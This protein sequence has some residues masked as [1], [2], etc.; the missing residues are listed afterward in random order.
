LPASLIDLDRYP[1]LDL[2]GARGR[3]LIAECRAQLRAEGAAN[4]PGFVRA[5]ALGPLVPEAEALLPRALVKQSRRNVY[6]RPVDPAW[7]PGHRMMNGA[8]SQIADDGTGLITSKKAT[9]AMGGRFDTELPA[10][11]GPYVFTN[12][13]QEQGWEL[14][15]NPDSTGAKPDP[16]EVKFII[17]RDD[18]SAE[19]A[20]EAGELDI[21]QI[22]PDTAVRYRE[23][24]PPESSMV[25][26]PGLR[27]TWLGMNTEHPKLAD[28]RVRQAIQNVVDVDSIL[29]AAWSG[30]T[31]RAYGIVPYGLIG[32]RTETAFPKPDLHKAR[33]LMA[34]A[35]VDDLTLTVAYQ[36][37]PDYNIAAQIVQANL[38]EIGIT[39]EPTPM[40]PGTFWIQ[41]IEAEGDQWKALQLYIVRYGDSPDPSQM[42]Q[43]YVSGQKGIWNWERWT[44]PEFDELHDAAMRESDEAKRNG[45]YLRMQEIMEATGAYVWISHEPVFWLHKSFLKPSIW[46]SFTLNV[47]GTKWIA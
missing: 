38:A 1:I 13:V 44:D 29:Q 15:R 3:A 37:Q 36:N 8:S 28:I 31:R 30:A 33:A 32:Y 12:F 40:E 5:E 17:V 42:T 4:L 46:E 25:E 14:Q 47:R 43:W 45:M 11:C 16:D 27:W 20:Y 21:T 34:E 2:D 35:G 6:V 10:V 7:Q 41:G 19:I 24:M 18:K 23:A 26:I 39:V 9:E 22:S